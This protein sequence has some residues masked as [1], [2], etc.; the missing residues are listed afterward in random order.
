[1][2]EN[3]IN[4]ITADLE[5]VVEALENARS[6]YQSRDLSIAHTEAE[7]ALLRLQKYQR[8]QETT[9]EVAPISE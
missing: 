3:D 7:N 4:L 8:E 9:P 6:V 1:M 2:P 5:S